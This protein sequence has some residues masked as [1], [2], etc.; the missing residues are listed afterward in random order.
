MNKYKVSRN[1]EGNTVHVEGKNE[2]KFF[3]WNNSRSLSVH[4]TV[5]VPKQFNLDLQTSGGDLIVSNITGRA[6]GNTSGG[7]LD[8]SDFTGPVKLETS[9][10]DIRIVHADGDLYLRTSGG[11]IRGEKV[12]GTFDIETSGGDIRCRDIDAKLRATTSGGNI[13]VT[14][15]SNKGANLGT[16]GGNVRIYL[17]KDVTADVDAE[18]TGGDVSCEMDFNGK[19]KDGR[20]NGRI[21]GGGSLISAHTSGGDITVSAVN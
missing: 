13:E 12:I 14:L 5:R 21:N 11:N 6:D 1:Q 10:G 9:G 3:Q 15:L 7:N 16:S 8:I 19:I 18:S 20:M 2:R 4:F 17:P